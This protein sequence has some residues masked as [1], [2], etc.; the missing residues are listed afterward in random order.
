MFVQKLF[1]NQYNLWLVVFVALG[2]ISTAYGLAIIGS[3]VGQPSFY[4]YFD[5]PQQGQPGYDYTTNM[6]AALNG[7]NSAGAFIGC[8]V[9]AW[10]S[11][12]YGRKRTMQIGCII[13]IIGGA[14]CGGAAHIGMLIVGRAIAGLGSGIL[15][16]VVPMYQA[17]VSTPETRG[18]MVCT[19]G[20]S[21]ALGYSLAG[22]MGFAC[23]HMSEDSPAAAFAW[24][25]PLSFQVLFPL[26]VLA[27]S[28]AIP[29][30]PR[31]L[32][33]QGRRQEA[34]DIVRRL[35]RTPDD[36]ED[37][38]GRTEFYLMEKQCEMDKSIKVRPFEIFRTPANR[39]RALTAFLLMWGNQ[40]LGIYVLAN[41]GVVIYATLGFSEAMSLL[42]NACGNSVTIIGN[43]VTV[44]LV[45][46]FGRRPLLIIGSIGCTVCAIFVCALSG[47]YADTQYKP[48]LNAII[49][50]IFFYSLVWSLFMDAT[51]YVYAAELFPYHLRPQGV[52]LGLSAFYLASEVT[53]VA[54]P[55]ALDKIEWRFWLVI[56]IPSLFYILIVIFLFPEVS[57]HYRLLCSTFCTG[58]KSA[59]ALHTPLDTL[60]CCFRIFADDCCLITN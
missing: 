20:I 27:G 29:Y 1:V 40:F 24:R 9:H 34:L 5:L 39:R 38:N 44:F 33:F 3:T 35:H 21:Y 14:I 48:G 2:T 13:L 12:K 17:E 54:A 32:L 56:I 6:I 50:F 58:V 28:R 55:I 51:Q 52:A 16:C 19:T 23:F 22:W 10:T 60:S 15:G 25:F 4:R 8:L 37:V 26:I 42:L 45:D 11:E 47:E 46:R 43:T 53:L 57:P 7:V 30:S 41:Y 18:A 59:V 36:A 49:F 31:W